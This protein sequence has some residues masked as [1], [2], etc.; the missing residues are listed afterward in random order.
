LGCSKRSTYMVSHCGH[1][2]ALHTNDEN[3]QKRAFLTADQHF[4]SINVNLPSRATEAKKSNSV[5]NEG[6]VH[7]EVSDRVQ[8]FELGYE[9]AMLR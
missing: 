6:Y 3:T 4:K 1:K 5:R 2:T 8:F 7:F 9:A